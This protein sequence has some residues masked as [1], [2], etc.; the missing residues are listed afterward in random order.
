MILV[1]L[2]A[3]AGA[4]AIGLVGFLGTNEPWDWR[5]FFYTFIR[6]GIG[7]AAIAYLSE[8]PYTEK[9]Y[10][11]AFIT[12]TSGDVIIKRAIDAVQVKGFKI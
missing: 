6:S 7:A 9:T 8:P 2:A 12:G 10:L 4:V 5:K 3:W 1:L 11:L